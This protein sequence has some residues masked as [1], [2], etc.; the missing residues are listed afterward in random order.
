MAPAY[1]QGDCEAAYGKLLS[2][3]SSLR[4]KVFLT[5]KISGYSSVRNQLYKEI[6][7]GLPGEKQQ[8]LLARAAELM[9]E[10]GVAKPGYFLEYFPGQRRSLDP[11]YLSNAMAPDY[12]H[13]VDG[14][15]RFRTYILESVEGSLK[16]VGTD[17]FD[18]LMCP[19]GANTPEELD[20][21]EIVQTFLEL[22]KQGKL[23]FLGVTAHNDPAGILRK[24]V[25][26][27]HYDA[28][29]IAY[30]IVNG[31]YVEDAIRYARLKDVGV[32]AMKVAMA[33]ATHHKELQPTP[34]WRID[35]LNRIL[36]GDMKPP[37]KAYTWV[38]QNPDVSGVISNLWDPAHIRENLS[39]AG[40]RVELRPA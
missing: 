19:H 39:V 32:I 24:A 17:H 28:A 15:P 21:P 1:G 4:Q 18:L 5:T 27:G 13:K 22:K 16:R 2:G 34:Q 3:K 14:S 10:R 9:A 20:T 12:A 36:P 25:D 7:D 38:L 8:K 37:L 26:L 6:F 11:A 23:R 31:G 40:K 33:V 29:M 35:K 30:N